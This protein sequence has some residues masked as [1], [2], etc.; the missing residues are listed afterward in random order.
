[1]SYSI[2]VSKSLAE[3]VDDALRL[4]DEDYNDVITKK[5]SFPVQVSKEC[6]VKP[7]S[8]E[9]KRVRFSND[10]LVQV[11]A[12]IS[13]LDLS[14]DERK[15]Y[16]WTAL[17]QDQIQER[18]NSLVAYTRIQGKRFASNTLGQAFEIVQRFG[19]DDLTGRGQSSAG[20]ANRRILAWVESCNARRGLEQYI[21][22]HPMAQRVVADHRQAVILCA[23]RRGSGSERIRN[24][25]LQFSAVSAT[26]AHIMGKADEHFASKM[27]L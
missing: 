11:E 19:P 4:L 14:L 16:W 22:S 17:E 27:Y 13:R 8:R 7:A 6:G 20:K 15:A 10:S 2:M 21:N 3:I 25:S 26:L 23:I 5:Y 24:V 9:R 1:M 18:A 12:T